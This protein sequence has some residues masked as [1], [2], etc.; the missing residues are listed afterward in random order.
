MDTKIIFRLK[1]LC[2]EVK[3]SPLEETASVKNPVYV[4]LNLFQH[5]C[6][7]SVREF[8]EILS[9]NNMYLM[10]THTSLFDAENFKPQWWKL[11]TEPYLQERIGRR[12]NVSIIVE[13]MAEYRSRCFG[14]NII[15]YD[16]IMDA[17]S[18]YGR[19]AR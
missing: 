19:I 14:N 10:V 6:I 18:Y 3:G 15:Y 17:L 2:K 1:A 12:K 9:D 13:R 4:L 16:D 7:R 11:L 5:K 8:D